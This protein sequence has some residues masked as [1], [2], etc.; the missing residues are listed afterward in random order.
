MYQ[1]PFSAPPSEDATAQDD[2]YSIAGFLEDSLG[3]RRGARQRKPPQ[4]DDVVLGSEM[5]NLITSSATIPKLEDEEDVNMN[6]SP[7]K[8]KAS[9]GGLQ[10]INRKA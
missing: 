5:D 7:R 9:P 6:S 8:H 10:S 4:R 1:Y 2:G 3:A